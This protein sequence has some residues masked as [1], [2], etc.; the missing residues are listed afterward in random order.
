MWRVLAGIVIALAVLLIVVSVISS[1]SSAAITY[2]DSFNKTIVLQVDASRIF[3]A[4]KLTALLRPIGGDGESYKAEC[5]RA[6]LRGGFRY[7]VFLCNATQ[8]PPGIY[9]IQ[10]EGLIPIEGVV[11]VR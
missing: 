6:L 3:Y 4:D 11:V 2:A 1:F 10:I 8:T 7:A 5:R 9:I